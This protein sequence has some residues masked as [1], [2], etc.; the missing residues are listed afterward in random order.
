MVVLKTAVVTSFRFFE[1][2]FLYR[3]RKAA[4][5]FQL[6]INGV[7]RGLELIF[8]YPSDIRVV[9]TNSFHFFSLEGINKKNSKMEN[10]QLTSAKSV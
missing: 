10:K 8:P 5:T 4:Q 7:A 2:M 9:S 3:L 6:Y 1:S